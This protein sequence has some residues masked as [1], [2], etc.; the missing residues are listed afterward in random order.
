MIYGNYD[1]RNDARVRVKGWLSNNE[2][3]QYSPEEIRQLVIESIRADRDPVDP[4]A[5]SWREG[6]YGALMGLMEFAEEE[7]ERLSPGGPQPA[8]RT[9]RSAHYAGAQ[10][11]A[12]TALDRV[13]QMRG[14]LADI[15]ASGRSTGRADQAL[16]LA[17]DLLQASVLRRALNGSIEAA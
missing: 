8:D 6:S 9:D 13:L 10:K 14:L 1:D 7:M 4:I 15:A 16:K 5:D 3:A 17:E 12:R 2:A 11:D